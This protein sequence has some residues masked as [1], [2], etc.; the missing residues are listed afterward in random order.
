MGRS[1]EVVL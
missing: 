1:T